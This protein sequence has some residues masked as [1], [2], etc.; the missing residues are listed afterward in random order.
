[1]AS[2]IVCSCSSLNRTFYGIETSSG[3]ESNHT[4]PG[5]NRTFYGIETAALLAIITGI[6]GLN[7]TFYGIETI[8]SVDQ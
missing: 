7:R 3:S 4:S 6:T 2:F 5:L 1:M 8:V